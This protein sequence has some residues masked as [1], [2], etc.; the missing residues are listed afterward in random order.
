M[1][2]TMPPAGPPA[3]TVVPGDVDDLIFSDLEYEVSS[4]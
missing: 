2:L 3:G 1:E 4:R